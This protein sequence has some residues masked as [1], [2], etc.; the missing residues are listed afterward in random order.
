MRELAA[1]LVKITVGYKKLLESAKNAE[2]G[3]L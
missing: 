2:L 3:L 1:C